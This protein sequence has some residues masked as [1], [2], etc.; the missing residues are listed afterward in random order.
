MFDISSK[1]REIITDI[2]ASAVLHR[3][4]IQQNSRKTIILPVNIS[5]IVPEVVKIAGYSLEFV[6][7]DTKDY[8]PNQQIVLDKIARNPTHYSGFIDNFTY[9][10]QTE[11]SEFYQEVN[12]LAPEL[13]IIED[14]CSNT[15]FF[16]FSGNADLTLYSTGYAKQ[17]DI[18]FGGYGIVDGHFQ[19]AEPD[20]TS[21]FINADGKN[22]Q[23]STHSFPSE[24]NSYFREIAEKL[25]RVL[26]HK[27]SLNK[28]YETQ[29]PIEIQ[30][31]SSFNQWRF[32]ILVK[33]KQEIIQRIFEADLFASSHFIPLKGIESDFPVAYGLHSK[34]INLF[35][36]LYY[37][38][39]QAFNTCKI[40]NRYL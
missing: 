6:D 37:S 12:T 10:V 9:G 19:E 27:I 40:I 20:Q 4:L 15:P 35:N 36:D 39:E 3:Y 34:V 21:L 7:I 28:I 16:E 26:P 17:A 18:G 33:N 25:D 31:A 30:M 1:N 32:N 11:R 29:L 38:E 5:G 13:F 23:F 8:S 24:M 2:R 14:R 22:Y